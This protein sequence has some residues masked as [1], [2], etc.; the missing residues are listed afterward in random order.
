METWLPQ[1]D[2]LR[3]LIG[4]IGLRTF[5]IANTTKKIWLERETEMSGIFQRAK[6]KIMFPFK[7]ETVFV[8][9]LIASNEKEPCVRKPDY[10]VLSLF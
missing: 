10:S 2:V 8:P 9:I 1:K 6:H 7:T 5:D 4:V 3:S